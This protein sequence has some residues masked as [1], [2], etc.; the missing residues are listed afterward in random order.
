MDNDTILNSWRKCVKDMKA[1]DVIKKLDGL[2]DWIQNSAQL[3]D[4]MGNIKLSY[5]MVKDTL[6]GSY[7]GLSKAN[8][9]LI[10]AALGYLVLPIDLAPDFIPVV[11]L[12]DDCVV[13]GWV[14][15]RLKDEL[16]KYKDF[17]KPSKRTITIE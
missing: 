5:E 4:L 12:V 9:A 10:V 14:F 2:W 8:L 1:E 16:A 11:G 17:R 7:K 13:L 3:K 6:N 15:V